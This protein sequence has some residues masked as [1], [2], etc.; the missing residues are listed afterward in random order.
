MS[1]HWTEREVV[2]SEA[3]WARIDEWSQEIDQLAENPEVKGSECG[4]MML[5][6]R[7]EVVSWIADYLHEYE[8]RLSGIL[9]FWGVK[10]KDGGE[11]E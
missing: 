7:R 10:A 1:R 5:M 9:E 11:L 2:Y 3:L 4:K 6:G 8:Q